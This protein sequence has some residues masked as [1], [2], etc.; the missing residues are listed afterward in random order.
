M[1]QCSLFNIQN[2]LKTFSFGAWNSNPS[3]NP[4]AE[5]RESN[6]PRTAAT[7]DS[8]CAT[9]GECATRAGQD[10]CTDTARQSGRS[11]HAGPSARFAHQLPVR[12]AP[13]AGAPVCARFQLHS[14]GPLM[15]GALVGRCASEQYVRVSVSHAAAAS[16]RQKRVPQLCQAPAA[17][18]LGC[19]RQR[20]P[21]QCSQSSLVRNEPRCESAPAPVRVLATSRRQRLTASGC[22]PG[23]EGMLGKT[24]QSPSGWVAEGGRTPRSGG[25]KSVSDSDSPFREWATNSLGCLADVVSPERDESGMLS[26]SYSE[27]SAVKL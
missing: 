13:S 19:Q 20:P 12:R 16:A 11:A 18:D 25:K 14:A 5:G 17:P 7:G 8:D 2:F 3:K 6:H 15:R 22:M 9:P 23:V 10:G 24:M 4:R 27:L 21:V 1:H 26:A